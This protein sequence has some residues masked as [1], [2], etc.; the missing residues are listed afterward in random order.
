MARLL[1]FHHALGLTPGVED[2]ARR[3]RE[4]GHDVLTPDLYG[5]ATFESL[6]DGVANAEDLGFLELVEA[7][8]KEAAELP[9]DTVYGG[10]SLGA[11]VAHNLAQ[12]RAG[13]RGAL[14][15]HHGDVPI[16]MFG[17]TWP[18]GVPV[19]LHAAR[20]DEFLEL[21]VVEGFVDEAGRGADARLYLYEGSG[22]LFTDSGLPEYD[23]AATALVLQRSL[24][25]L[26]E[27]D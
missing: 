9:P 25:L 14:L 24:A 21:P 8:E 2:F 23:S 17:D 18:Q 1:L 4:A 11:L 16:A 12:N 10:F 13:A 7:G 5:G 15:Y 19:Q 22:H 27:L 6:E 3:I 26:G 20:G